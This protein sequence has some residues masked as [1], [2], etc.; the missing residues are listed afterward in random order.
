MGAQ[1]R[2]LSSRVARRSLIALAAAFFKGGTS[3]SKSCGLIRRIALGMAPW[4]RAKPRRTMIE[5]HP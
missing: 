4:H 1:A 3:L 2:A 5:G